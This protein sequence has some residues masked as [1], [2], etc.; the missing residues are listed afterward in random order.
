MEYFD[1][2]TSIRI[3]R[4][5]ETLNKIKKVNFVSISSFDDVINEA[6]IKSCGADYVTQ[7]PCS[8]S[9]MINILE[10]FGLI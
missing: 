4:E 6:I 5:M 8:R 2:S 9:N 7:K 1:G 3:L 10:S